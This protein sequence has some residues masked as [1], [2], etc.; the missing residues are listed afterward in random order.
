MNKKKVISFI[1]DHLFEEI[2]FLVM[3]YVLGA[4]V[5]FILGLYAIFAAF[6][7]IIYWYKKHYINSS[8]KKKLE[9]KNS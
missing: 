9:T 2:T 3:L 6:V 4:S 1:M 5:P 7:G 8:N